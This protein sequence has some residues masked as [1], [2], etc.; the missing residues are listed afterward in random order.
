[1]SFK[2]KPEDFGYVDGNRDTDLLSCREATELAN[3]LLEAHLKTLPKAQWHVRRE[4]GHGESWECGSWAMPDVKVSYNAYELN[5]EWKAEKTA[6]L[7]GIEVIA[8]KAVPKD[9][10]VLVGGEGRRV[11]IKGLKKN[12]IE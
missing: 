11:V 2:F 12:D 6:L 5:P 10:A 9:L 4:Y 7:W 3:A 8:N 1:M